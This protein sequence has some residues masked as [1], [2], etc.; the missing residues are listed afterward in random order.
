MSASY[1]LSPHVHVCVSGKQ[2]ILLDLERDKYLALAHA[3]EW[4]RVPALAHVLEHQAQPQACCPDQGKPQ[5]E[6]ARRHAPA[7]VVVASVT[8]R[9]KKAR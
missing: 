3:P 5:A 2:V 1:F 6:C 9:Q 7:S 4:E 8:R